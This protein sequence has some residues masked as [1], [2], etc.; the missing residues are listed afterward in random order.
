MIDEASTATSGLEDC[1]IPLL[2]F[3]N[4]TAP[5]EISPLPLHDA[6]PILGFRRH[7]PRPAAHQGPGRGEWGAVHDHE[8][9]QRRDPGRGCV[10]GGPCRGEMTAPKMTAFV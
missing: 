6:L 3:F 2:F 1:D 7:R 4:D 9:G 10:P 8:Q 5:P